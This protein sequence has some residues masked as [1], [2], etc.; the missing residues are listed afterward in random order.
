MHVLLVTPLWIRHTS[1][2]ELHDDSETPT[3]VLSWAATALGI[4]QTVL[5]TRVGGEPV[6]ETPRPDLPVEVWRLGEGPGARVLRSPTLASLF[7]V[8]HYV[9]HPERTPRRARAALAAAR[10]FRLPLVLSI[11]HSLLSRGRASSGMD[12][13]YLKELQNLEET[14]RAPRRRS[15][16]RR[17]RC[18]TC[19]CSAGSSRRVACIFCMSTAQNR[20]RFGGRL[21]PVRRS[22]STTRCST[23]ARRPPHRR[24]AWP[25]GR[26]GDLRR[27]GDLQAGLVLAQLHDH[28]V[29]VT[30][31]SRQQRSGQ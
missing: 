5:T 29:A 12:P 11:D 30:H 27:G 7:D 15:S 4:R 23:S 22:T 1:E 16:P 31:L 28:L 14:S 8:L 6:R 26:H 13:A 25:S 18:A 20:P 10:A 24:A 2:A 3:S 21:W 9:H 17:S 19:W